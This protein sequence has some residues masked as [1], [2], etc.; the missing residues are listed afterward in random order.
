MKVCEN[1]RT[2]AEDTASFCSRCGQQ[3]PHEPELPF[4]GVRDDTGI[5]RIT[6]APVEEEFQG[7]D[8]AEDAARHSAWNNDTSFEEYTVELVRSTVTV[9]THPFVCGTCSDYVS[10]TDK[11]KCNQCGEINWVKREGAK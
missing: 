7:K 4:V 2:Q 3:L 10:P 5:Y 8:A 9:E 11:G 6:Y 1:C